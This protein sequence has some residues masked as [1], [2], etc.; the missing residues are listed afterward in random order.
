MSAYRFGTGVV[1]RE[2]PDS[3][4]SGMSGLFFIS[5][6]F[7]FQKSNLPHLIPLKFLI[8]PDCVGDARGGPCRDSAPFGVAHGLSLGGVG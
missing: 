8:K 4:R 5:G 7:L 6:L 1:S 3:H 2:T